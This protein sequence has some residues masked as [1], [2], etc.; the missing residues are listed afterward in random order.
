MT[1]VGPIQRF[2]DR[3]AG[4]YDLIGNAPPVRGW[5]RRAVDALDL[6]GGETVVEM[7][8]GT[9]ANLPLLRERVGPSGQVIG[10]DLTSGML[11]YARERI[12][13]GG[14]ENVHLVH[15]DATAPP[16]DGDV[17]AV[18]ASF[19][20]GMFDDPDAVVEEWLRLLGGA[21]RIALLDA[22]PSDRPAAIPLNAVF[23]AFTRL[24]APASRTTPA[25]PAIELGRRVRTAHSEVERLAKESNRVA[26]GFGFLRLTAGRLA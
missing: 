23:R 25:S 20:V 24:T 1:D 17:D 8:C 18:F 2:Y 22:G 10:L 12:E 16:I 19:V 7:G 26:F 21:G 9:G 14:W 15:G 3:W 6:A 11:D 4:P 13:R 5:R